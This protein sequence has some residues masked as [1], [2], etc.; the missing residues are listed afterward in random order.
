MILKA[1]TASE[2]I[3]ESLDRAPRVK[4]VYTS[5]K[6]RFFVVPIAYRHAEIP[7]RDW[8]A[9]ALINDKIIDRVSYD[10]ARA[11]SSKTDG[12][13]V[14]SPDE[15]WRR[16]RGVCRDYAAL[17]EHLA[18]KAGYETR[19]I[20]STT[21]N[22]AWNE[23]RLRGRWWTVDVTWNDGEILRNGRAVPEVLRSDPDHR[24]RYFLISLD[25]ERSLHSAGHLRSTHDASDAR[26]VDYQRTLEAGPMIER[27]KRLLD[28]TNDLL[29]KRRS[30]TD[31]HNALVN[32]INQTVKEHNAQATRVDQAP[33][34]RRLQTLRSALA[35]IAA[36]RQEIKETHDRLRAELDRQHKQFQHFAA[37]YPL[38]ISFTIRE[39]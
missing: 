1:Y 5:N 24:R 34:A 33:Y 16:R 2:D 37:I 14:Q 35:P 32:K 36:Q 8:R 29:M 26:V 13:P 31:E 22:H 7:E 28:Q 23:V 25:R 21:L 11:A 39:K 9:L 18:R 12:P 30:L 10:R 27:L 3:M 15:T 38:A 17:F 6:A 19:S 4:R 20:T